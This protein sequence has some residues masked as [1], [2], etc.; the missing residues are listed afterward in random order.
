MSSKKSYKLDLK[1]V[2]NA[3]DRKDRDFYTNL[4]EEEKKAYVPLVIMRYM[5]SLTDQSPLNLYAVMATND[6]V[7]IGFWALSKHPE[8]QHHLLCMTG[9]GG[10]QYRPWI[11]PSKKRSSG[12]IN[13]FILNIFPEMNED[14]LNIFKSGMDTES[15]TN[16]VKSSGANDKETK[17]LIEAW[18][19]QKN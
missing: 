10:K 4:S 18:K 7:N 16:F 14:E 13:E 1:V 17:E 2:L 19:K 15:W 5:S 9:V 6:L 3:L 12:K 8:L 11:T